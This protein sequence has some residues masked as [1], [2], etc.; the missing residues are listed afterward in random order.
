MNETGSPDLLATNLMTPGN[1]DG[2]Q[3]EQTWLHTIP[4]YPSL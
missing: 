1:R 4:R 2:Q 3:L